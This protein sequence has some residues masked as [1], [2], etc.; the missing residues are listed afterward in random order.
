MRKWMKWFTSSRECFVLCCSWFLR[1]TWNTLNWSVPAF[2]SRPMDARSAIEKRRYCYTKYIAVVS[3][4][5][6]F[7]RTRLGIAG[8]NGAPKMQSLNMSSLLFLGLRLREDLYAACGIE[9]PKLHK[10]SHCTSST[11]IQKKEDRQ[12]GST[13][14]SKLEVSHLA[15]IFK[16]MLHLASLGG[17][18]I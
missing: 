13:K 4:F 14:F 3:P 11:K 9:P 17:R 10:G 2:S 5:G 1:T 6:V 8:N 12:C 7:S 18:K 16:D 15:E